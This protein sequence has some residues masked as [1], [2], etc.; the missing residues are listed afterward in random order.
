MTFYGAVI[1]LGS[2]GNH[3]T[4][5]CGDE[6]GI[7][8]QEIEQLIASVRPLVGDEAPVTL[9]TSRVDFGSGSALREFAEAAGIEFSIDD[10][11]Q[12]A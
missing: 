5:R 10:I 3:I 9:R 12:E 6:T 11:V 1:R 7:G 2:G 4:V 8:A